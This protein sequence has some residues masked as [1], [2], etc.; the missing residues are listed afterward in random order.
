MRQS[1][2]ERMMALAESKRPE[3]WADCQDALKELL[4]EYLALEHVLEPLM[5]ETVMIH[6]SEYIGEVVLVPHTLWR[7]TMRRLS[8]LIWPLPKG[9]Q[10]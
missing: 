6:H 8:E 2:V 5:T 4:R 3:E 7:E 10:P 1:D 9:V